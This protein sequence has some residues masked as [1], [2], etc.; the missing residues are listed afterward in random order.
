[1]AKARRGAGLVASCLLLWGSVASAAPT[2]AQ[3]LSFR[4]KQEG[5]VYTL[6]TSQEQDSCKVELDKARTG[7][8]SGWL[9]KDAKGNILRRYFDTN[10]DN[11]ID[12]W[13]YY[14]NGIEV[15]R[16]TDTNFNE[17]ADQY[18]WLN[19]GG[20][21]WG[22]DLNED[23]R[24]DT[25]KQISAEEVSQEILQAVAKKDFSR[26]QALML[27]DSDL[28]ALDLTAGERAQVRETMRKASTRF[29]V[30]AAKLSSV[31]DKVRWIYLETDTPQ[32]VPAETGGAGRT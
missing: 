15:Y 25:W 20:T 32:C 16:E 23:G 31:A 26:L 11:R 30:A 14:L 1:M 12:V 5:I 21:K 17:K 6:P 8:G 28:K 7:R 3:M 18:R 4:P 2:V 13:S 10:G 27:S 19:A 9:L 24:I 29:Q 22:L